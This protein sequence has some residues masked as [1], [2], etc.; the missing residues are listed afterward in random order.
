MMRIA[1]VAVLLLIA[2][3]AAD[4][5]RSTLERL[6]HDTVL[7][8][9]L[10]VIVMPTHAIPI[11][12]IE[13]VVRNGAFTQLDPADEG[14]PHLLEHMLFKSFGGRSGTFA[15]RAAELHAS[16]NGSTSDE[17]VTYYLTLPSRNVASGI[18][19]LADLMRSPHFSETELETEQRVVRGELQ[20]NAADPSWVMSVSLNRL[21]WGAAAGRKEAGGTVLSVMGADTD[22]LRRYYQRYYVPNNAALV[23]TGDVVPAEV[24]DEAADHF[25]RWKRGSDPFTDHPVPPMPS[26][27]RDTVAVVIDGQSRD[28][29]VSLRWQGPSVRTAPEDTYAADVFSA[30]VNQPHSGMQK[31]LVDTGLF[32]SAWVSY[33]TLNQVGPITLTAR[34]TP[35][36][37]VP[38]MRALRSELSR[39]DDPDYFSQEELRIASKRLQVEAALE[40]EGGAMLA[41]TIGYWWSVAGLDYYL[42]YTDGLDAQR[43]DDLRRYVERYIVR[44]PKVVGMLISQSTREDHEAQVQESLTQWF[45]P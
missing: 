34:T 8:N 13:V 24:F 19:L 40:L 10:H 25:E 35:D 41:H 37:V 45:W 29:T 23:I 9:G 12:T 28:I 17:S 31:R 38:A 5:Q 33:A 1:I 22:R 36:K 27:E 20:R 42:G 26:L 44:R 43:P 39:F 6:L 11:A 2:P 4:A 14:I 3:A 21:L 15:L 32:Q 7:A 18:E 30:L 16:Y